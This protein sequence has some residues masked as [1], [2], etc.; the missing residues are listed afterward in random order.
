[1]G[2]KRFVAFVKR[3]PGVD[4]RSHDMSKTYIGNCSLFN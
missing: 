4:Q 3:T 2:P 1:M